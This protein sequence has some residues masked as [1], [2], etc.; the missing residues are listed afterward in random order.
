MRNAGDI[1]NNNT[2]GYNTFNT[3]AYNRY[4]TL[5]KSYGDY[6]TNATQRNDA[7]A[8][9]IRGINTGNLSSV[10]NGLGTLN[11]NF[12]TQIAGQADQ[13]DPIRTDLN[14][15]MQ[16]AQQ[17]QTDLYNGKGTEPYMEQYKQGIANTLRD[18]VGNAYA[19]MANK[20]L[21]GG[22]NMEQSFNNINRNVSDSAA[23][24]Y[25]DVT[26]ALSN[27]ANSGYNAALTGANALTSNLAQKSSDIRNNTALSADIYGKQTATEQARLQSELAKYGLI[28]DNE[29]ALQSNNLSAINGQQQANNTLT[30]AIYKATQGKVQ[31]GNDWLN[32][33]RGIN[34]DYTSTL[35]SQAS[36]QIAQ[37]AAQRG[38]NADR[39]AVAKE[40]A[41]QA[42]V[43]INNA[44]QMQQF[45]MTWNISQPQ[46]TNVVTQDSGGGLLSSALGGW[47]SSGFV[48]L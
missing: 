45:L 27:Y 42:G 26:N 24:K 29:R 21:I 41:A 37:I 11:N 36:A 15:A 38:I 44:Q 3:D 18:T 13:Y 4:N 2:V 14:T 43:D 8:G 47:A 34:Q 32:M 20:G 30:D 12:Q 35:N 16:L 19:G 23:Q 17:R 28:S 22:S 9:D 46:D 40:Q 6:S 25:L 10:Y 33:Q 5:N 31:A 7:I 39:L 1:Y 48:G